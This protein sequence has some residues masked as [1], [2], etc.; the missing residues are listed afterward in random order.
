[1]PSKLPSETSLLEMLNNHGECSSAVGVTPN[2]SDEASGLIINLLGPAHISGQDSANLISDDDKENAGDKKRKKAS[3]AKH[4]VRRTE[5]SALS[6]WKRDTNQTYPLEYSWTFWITD[7]EKDWHK[8]LERIQNFST[9]HGFWQLFNVL[10]EPSAFRH[11]TYNLF[12]K[13]IRPE[14]EDPANKTG[15]KWSVGQAW[16]AP[17]VDEVWLDLCLICIG[18]Y[19]LGKYSSHVNGVY[20]TWKPEGARISV[21]LNTI[22]KDTVVPT[23]QIIQKCLQLSLKKKLPMEFAY[24]K[25][26][27]GKNR[28]LYSL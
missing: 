1:M 8:A 22:D 2:S 15:G 5:H 13:G 24:F 3:T 9:V 27:R 19:E 4:P 7:P 16:S 11:Y 17:R 20:V 21:W 14:W 12:K 25:T 10:L 28:V 6:R 23:G 26:T 18:G